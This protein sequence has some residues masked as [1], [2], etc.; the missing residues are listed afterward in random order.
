MDN[1]IPSR[2]VEDNQIVFKYRSRGSWRSKTIQGSKLTDML[3]KT[4]Q[5][6]KKP[7]TLR[8]KNGSSRSGQA[9][10]RSAREEDWECWGV[11]SRNPEVVMGS[12]L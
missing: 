9:V 11:D 8:Y 6:K 4:G 10:H 12:S 3:R 5:Q 7:H 2:H 1:S